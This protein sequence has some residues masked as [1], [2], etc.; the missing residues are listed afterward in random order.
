MKKNLYLLLAFIIQVG[1]C[2][3][4][5]P[6]APPTNPKESLSHLEM[7]FEDLAIVGYFAAEK[8]LSA[9]Q[10]FKAF[11]DEKYSEEQEVYL[12]MPLKNKVKYWNT[13]CEQ[14]CSC[15]FYVGF[16]EYLQAF[17]FHLSTTEKN[18]VEKLRAKSSLEKGAIAA[19]MDKA[20]W[21]R[22]SRVFGE[23]VKRST[24]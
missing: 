20:P 19:C 4:P 5:A 17:N 1:G 16:A 10:V 14:T 3:T 18:A 9:K 6:V 2:S 7:S 15:D 12:K 11:A 24:P 21:V 22:Q 8:S 13:T 23:I